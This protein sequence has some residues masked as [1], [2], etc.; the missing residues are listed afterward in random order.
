LISHREL[1]SCLERREIV[2][3]IRLLLIV[4]KRLRS[5]TQAA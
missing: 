1:A 3:R 4:R 5:I 2:W